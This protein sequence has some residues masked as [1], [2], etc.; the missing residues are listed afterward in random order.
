EADVAIDNGMISAVGKVGEGAREID[1]RGKLVTPGWVDI[2]THYDGQA[3]WDS[4]LAPSS[5]HGVTSVVMGNCGVGFA[6]VKPGDEQFLIELMEGVEDIPGAAL[7]EGID[8]KWETFGEYLDALETMPRTIDVG[9]QIPHGAVR[10]Y[11]MGRRCNTDQPS[12]GE[13]EA[14]CALVR[15]GLAAGALGFSTSRTF[16][17]RD[18]HGVHVPGTYAESKEM[19][20]L[21]L[22]MKGFDHGVL[23]IVSDHFGEEEEWRWVKQVARETGRPITLVPTSAAAYEGGRVFKI[24]QEA[25]AE[26]LNIF[27]QIA[28]RPTGVLHGLTSSFHVFVRHPTYA[29][30]LAGLS[31]EDRLTRMRQPEMR[32][33]IMAENPKEG[34]PVL[35]ALGATFANIFPLGE[36]PNYEPTK[37]QSIAGIAAQRGVDPWEVMYDLMI[38]DDGRELF[39]QP[40]GFYG[41]YNLDQIRQNLAHPQVLYGLSDGG[42]HCGVIADAGMPS[43]ILTHW[44]RDRKS[45]QL[46][47]EMLVH[48]LSRKTAMAYGLNDRGALVPGLRGDVNVIDFTNL[49]LDRPEAIYDLPAGGRRLIQRVTG[50]DYT[51]K[52]GAVT[53]DHGEHTGALPGKVLRAAQ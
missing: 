22:A 32:A 18:K 34:D 41:D 29:K 36:K 9:T 14:M 51:V 33:R 40:L 2:H 5:W 12:D 37:E 45:G 48:S 53:F 30:E 8:W 46:P 23:E 27:P 11:V 21:G 7:T 20:A 52:S 39:Y 1:A 26:G 43:F 16:L 6:P 35:G 10:A 24:A 50:Y 13:I 17:H 47:L 31:H 15:D 28:G 49:Q 25:A 4:I 38:G 19:L 42:A 44:A 3:T